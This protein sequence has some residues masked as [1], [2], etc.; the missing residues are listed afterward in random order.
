MNKFS[1]AALAL[2][3]AI[4]GGFLSY[5]LVMTMLSNFRNMTGTFKFL[6]CAILACSA[7]M[8]VMPIGI[9]IFV[10]DEEKERQKAEAA[11]DLDEVE[12]VQ[13]EVEPVEEPV[14]VATRDE[15]EVSETDQVA[16]PAA[17]EELD[18]SKSVEIDT[19]D[20]HEQ[21]DSVEFEADVYVTDENEAEADEKPSKKK[22]GKRGKK[23]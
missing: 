3:A 2:I 6:V 12:D 5:M 10:R 8:A 14:A 20:L 7:L 19:S 15:V 21:S 23:K 18:Q 17:G 1:Y 13:D 9:M 22:R 4:P 16:A 11:E